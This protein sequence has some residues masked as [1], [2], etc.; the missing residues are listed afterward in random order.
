MP[1]F[2]RNL[3]SKE[4]SA[5][6]PHM[7]FQVPARNL[8]CARWARFL[9]ATHFGMTKSNVMSNECETSQRF[10]GTKVPQNYRVWTP[11][12]KLLRMTECGILRG[13][14][15]QN[16]NAKKN[17]RHC[18]LRFL[19]IPSRIELL[20]PPWKGGVLTDWPWDHSMVAM[21]RLEPLTLRVW[22]A[23]SS[24]LSYIAKKPI[25]ICDFAIIY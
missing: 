2:L 16:D 18:A 17:A 3:R 11:R 25:T 4:C 12:H 10:F 9:S 24:Q 20:T 6:L 19:V 14:A 15:T 21:S 1:T 5:F 23:R 22:T 7:S 13:K 8:M